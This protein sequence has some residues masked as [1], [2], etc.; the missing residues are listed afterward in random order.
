[1]LTIHDVL[2]ALSK[3]LESGSLHFNKDNLCCVQVDDSV[4]NIELVTNTRTLFVYI[5]IGLLPSNHESTSNLL[6]ELMEA[7]L[8]FQGTTDNALFGLDKA[9]GEIFLFQGFSIDKLDEVLFVSSCVT[10]IEL[11]KIWKNKVLEKISSHPTRIHHQI[12]LNTIKFT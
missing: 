9:Q 10:M 3:R 5:P 12:F 8:F 11:A 2:R 4:L 6:Q 1:M 7:N